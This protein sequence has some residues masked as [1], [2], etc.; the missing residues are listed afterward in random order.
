MFQLE[1]ISRCDSGSADGFSTESPERLHINFAKNA[2]R[3][4]NKKNYIKQMTKWLTRQEACHRFANYLQWTVL[5]YLAELS[6]VSEVR[7]DDDKDDEYDDPDSPD[8]F[9][10]LGYSIA[11]AP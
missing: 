8:Q 11:K 1:T 5:D 2:Y 6:V 10:G 4:T 7:E 9:G 3:A